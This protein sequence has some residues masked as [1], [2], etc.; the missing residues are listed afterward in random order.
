MGCGMMRVRRRAAIAAVCVFLILAGSLTGCSRSVQAF[1]KVVADHKER[2][3]DAMSSASQATGLEALFQ[4][5]TAVA[6]L[7]SMWH[8]MA[9]AAPNEIRG[10]AEAVRDTWDE[11]SEA[12]SRQAW[13]TA[14]GAM[15]AG[16]R[17]M[18]RLDAYV[19]ANCGVEYSFIGAESP[20]ASSPEPAE[21]P[22]VSEAPGDE[23]G[24]PLPDVSEQRWQRSETTV[25][26]GCAQGFEKE[27]PSGMVFEPETGEFGPLPVPE[28]PPGEDVVGGRCTVI[29]SVGS[30]RVVYLMHTRTPASGLEPAQDHRRF[31]SLAV[32][33]GGRDVVRNWPLAWEEGELRG[34]GA[35]VIAAGGG[36]SGEEAAALDGMT[37]DVLWRRKRNGVLKAAA[38]G[39]V[40]LS[41]RFGEST[42]FV[43]PATGA[44]WARVEARELQELSTG[45]AVTRYG[46]GGVHVAAWFAGGKLR[47]VSRNVV[48]DF[49]G[50]LLLRDDDGFEIRDAANLKT[51]LKRTGVAYSGLGATSLALAGS[52]LYLTTDDGPSVIDVQTE[53]KVADAW[54]LRP[55]ERLSSGWTV[56]LEGGEDQIGHPSCFQLSDLTCEPTALRLVKDVTG[57]FPGPWW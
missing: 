22:S 18:Q 13:L 33:P 29:G 48:A 11:V 56:V 14:L 16:A 7:K 40:V 32:A 24:V 36:D 19:G 34:V 43:N 35:T 3:L 37:G 46:A 45:V 55:T 15:V 21:V 54:S 53:A 25:Y 17:P 47:D 5:A 41:E 31:I 12:A 23:L 51:Q 30:L 50:R 6:D 42:E 1:C 44:V 4:A 10:D 28:V 39:V 49:G 52:Y 26:A 20:P 8:D 2:Y 38:P 27:L 9:A 57:Q